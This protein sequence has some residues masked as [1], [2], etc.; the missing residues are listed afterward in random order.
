MNVRQL[1]ARLE[2]TARRHAGP[3]YRRFRRHRNYR[4][5]IYAPPRT[6]S[7]SLAQA[8][9]G[10]L[11]IQCAME[12]FNSDW[13][14]NVRERVSD[15]PSLK[16]EIRRL[17]RRY[18]GFKHIWHQNGFPFKGQPEFNDYLLTGAADRVVLL[19]RRNVLRRIVSDQIAHQAGVFH[20]WKDED[21][22]KRLAHRFQPLD[23]NAIKE[24]LTSERDAIVTVERRLGDAGIPYKRLWYEDLFRAD[25]DDPKHE[26]LGDVIAF[27]TGRPFQPALLSPHSLTT[28]NPAN[29]QTNVNSA[30][31]YEAVPNIHEIE[32]ELG[33]AQ[34]GFLFR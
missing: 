32:N 11:G 18:N 5:L 33:C 3:A 15:L 26:A 24:Q 1:M 34:T 21:R 19:N 27:I 31:A 23:I 2:G 29:A 28:I 10:Y 14:G 20:L 12:P 8:L 13:R 16:R 17:W 9:N 30:A 25:T 22:V 6:G 7:S 4:F